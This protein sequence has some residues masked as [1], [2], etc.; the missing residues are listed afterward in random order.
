MRVLF[1]YLYGRGGGYL[2]LM[3]LLQAM[4]EVYPDDE[5]CLVSGQVSTIDGFK[6]CA[7]VQAAFQTMPLGKEVKRAQLNTY[8]LRR[9]VRSVQPDVIWSINMGPYCDLG[10]PH[11]MTMNNAYQVTSLD[12]LEAHPSGSLH[13]KMIRGFFRQSLKHTSTVIVQTETIAN[14]L[15]DVIGYRGRVSVVSKAVEADDDAGFQPLLDSQRKLID[16]GLIPNAITFLYVSDSKPHKNHQVLFDAVGIL[17]SKGVPARLAVTLDRETV[18]EIGG[19]RSEKLID[20]GHI[21]PF[22]WVDKAQVKPLYDACDACVM[23]SRLES[24]SSAH[25]EAM[26]WQKPQVTIDLPYAREMCRDAAVYADG[27]SPEQWASQ[28]QELMLSS[29][30]RDRLTQAGLKEIKRYPKS[31]TEMALTVHGVLEEAVCL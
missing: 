3:R 19:D 28:M 25:L 5:F 15:R 17:Q 6:D 22:G 23:P 1:Y 10:I 30:L 9:I 7:N 4:V 31:W 20:D 21:L 26:K 2:N 13:L 8:G 29:E 16:N 18:I 27:D 24:Q 12:D 14:C 11:V